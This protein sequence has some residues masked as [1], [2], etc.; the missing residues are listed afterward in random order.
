MDFDALNGMAGDRQPTMH[1]FVWSEAPPYIGSEPGEDG[2]CLRD[3][4]CELL[5]WQPGS[6]EWSRF[7]I[8]GPVGEDTFRLA[9]HLGLASYDLHRDWNELIADMAHPGAAL[10]L[11]HR[12]RK[13]H[14]VYVH[15]VRWLM[16]HWPVPDG[17]PAL[18]SQ[19]QLISPGW[20]LTYPHIARGPELGAVIVDRRQMPRPE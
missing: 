20:P 10:F 13:A 1:G 17:R 4:Y 14:I 8:E 5:G 16:H 11:F 12:Y 6:A 7:D 9:D 15:D 19:R 18:P 3:A 2:W